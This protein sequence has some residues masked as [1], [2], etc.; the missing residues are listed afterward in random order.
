VLLELI[1]AW[2]QELEA[3]FDHAR[4]KDVPDNE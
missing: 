1:H 4:E 2:E 3:Q